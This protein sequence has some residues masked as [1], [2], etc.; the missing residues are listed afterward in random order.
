MG[1][2]ASMPRKT[3]Q[4]Y[5]TIIT[6]IRAAIQDGTY[7]PGD[8][9]PSEA[10]LCQQFDSSR[11]PVRQAMSL[12]RT[13]G[14]IS[15]GRGRRS[16]VLT[17]AATGTFDSILSISEWLVSLGKE[18]GQRTEWIARRPADEITAQHLKV[19]E[20]EKVVSMLRLRLADDEPIA[21]ERI[22][23]PAEIG[24]HIL[25]FDTDSGSI[26]RVL[27]DKGIDFESI[28]RTVSA[29]L[30]TDEDARLLGIAPGSPLLRLGLVASDKQGHILEFA[31]YRYNAEDLAMHLNSVRGTP[32]PAWLAPHEGVSDDLP[33]S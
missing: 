1:Q 17:T 30:A 25:D 18:P 8:E 3:S 6:H 15:T 28:T 2:A 4:R 10:E 12:L 31:D 13:E 14:L 33:A 9:L 27:L 21:V 32:T 19:T 11:G 16:T 5:E 22:A 20:G 7:R 26:H 23:F 24:Q 29:M